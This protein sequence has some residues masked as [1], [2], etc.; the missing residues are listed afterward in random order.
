ML[1]FEGCFEARIAAATG[2]QASCIS[3][4][5]PVP[6]TCPA[7]RQAPAPFLVGNQ[8]FLPLNERGRNPHGSPPKIH[9]FFEQIWPRAQWQFSGLC[10]RQNE[11]ANLELSAHSPSTNGTCK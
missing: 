10:N 9:R 7:N 4:A 3:H 11:A 5:K 2:M 1:G 6:R 8:Q